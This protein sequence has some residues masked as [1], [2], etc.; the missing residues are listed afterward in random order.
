VHVTVRCAIRS[1]RAQF[2]F[3]TVRGVIARANRRNPAQFRIVEFSVQATHVHLI[4][5]AESREALSRGLRGLSVSLA[6]QVNRLL[7]R[8][9]ALVADRWHEHALTTPRAVRHAL[10]YLFEN[11]RKHGENVGQLD[12]LSS[13]I[14]FRSLRG[15]TPAAPCEVEP[16]WVPAFDAGDRWRRELNLERGLA[17]PVAS[18]RSWLLEKGWQRRRSNPPRWSPLQAL[19]DVPASSPQNRHRRVNAFDQRRRRGFRRRSS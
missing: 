16:H 7:F 14:Y 1:L 3:P 18:A 13:A 10:A 5:E 6:R 15:F 2:V 17:T 8:R 11:A 9:G 12:G 4:V 19:L